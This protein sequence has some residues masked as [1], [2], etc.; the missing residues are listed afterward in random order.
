MRAEA[1]AGRPALRVVRA[2]WA[3]SLQDRGRFGHAHLGVGRGGAV[4]PGAMGRIGRALGHDPTGP[5]IETAG[6]LVLEALRPVIVLASHWSAPLSLRTGET[7]A[8]DP[9]AGSNW[10]T[11]GVAGGLLVP[12]LLG[13][14]SADT[15]GGIVP[16]AVTEGLVLDVGTDSPVGPGAA[17]VIVAP[18][19]RDTAAVMRGPRV[20]WFETEA[21]DRLLGSEWVV[22]ET[23]RVGV[24]LSGPE[25]GRSRQGEL[26][27]EGLVAG[28]I[29]VPPD[30][31][32]IVMG[33][34]HPVTGGY[35]VIAVVVAADLPGVLDRPVGSRIRFVLR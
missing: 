34:D 30:G 27:S 9:P 7:I 22:T 31:R 33:P 17:D 2:G 35:P 8:V 10:V 6:G 23:S 32:P 24:R 26:P 28:A 20:D 18:P 21:I 29:Q 4:D 19:R 14:S 15:L 25:L 16:L 13:S 3:T 1:D 12:A 5:V 11:V